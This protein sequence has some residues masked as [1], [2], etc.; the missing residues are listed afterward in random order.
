MP[1]TIFATSSQFERALAC[2]VIMLAPVAPCFASELWSGFVSA[3]HR[4]NN[5]EEIAW[6]KDVLE[7]RWPKID[8]NYNMDI[9]C[10]VGFFFTSYCNFKYKLCNKQKSSVSVEISKQNVSPLYNQM[11]L[12][13]IEKGR[14][15]I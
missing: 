8:S 2:Q 4:L 9:V 12:C 10:Q 13:F 15:I 5:T 6:D 11:F 1:P 3:P 14:K 7:Q